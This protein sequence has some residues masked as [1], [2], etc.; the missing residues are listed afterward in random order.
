MR[1]VIVTNIVSLDGYYAAS[2]GN[3]L[4]LNMDE[5]FDVYNRE[6]IE[7]ADTVLLGRT[8]FEEF[9]SYW[10]S[11]ADAPEDPENP[12][13]DEENRRISRAWAVTPNVVV[14]DRYTVPPAHPWA[15][16]TTVVARDGVK[17]WLANSSGE[18]VVFGS[19]TMWNALLDQGLIDEVHLMVSPTVLG[20]G[21]PAFTAP[22][23][24]RLLG[25]RTFDGSDNVL[26]RY[27]AQR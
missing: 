22:R 4:V 6:R 1:S 3:P 13:L 21:V 14:S 19:R 26:H 10:P 2:D 16:H 17:E 5:A 24:L 20:D 15:D 27:A 7:A 23:R 8:S 25:T 9:G 12:A 18:V 11:I